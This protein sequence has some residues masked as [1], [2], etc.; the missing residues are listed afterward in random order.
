[1]TSRFLIAI[2]LVVSAGAANTGCIPS[3]ESGLSDSFVN[4]DVPIVIIDPDEIVVPPATFAS[5]E[6]EIPFG[7]FDADSD[8][9]ILWDECPYPDLEGAEPILRIGYSV[10]G[11][12][13]PIDPADLTL[14]GEPITVPTCSEVRNFDES[15]RIAAATTTSG[16][17]HL[18]TWNS[19]PY[20]PTSA[21]VTFRIAVDDGSFASEPGD[22]EFRVA[23][24]PAF[25]I[26]PL[27]IRPG[28]ELEVTLSGVLTSWD[29]TTVVDSSGEI[30]VTNFVALSSSSATATFEHSSD[31]AQEPRTVTLVTPG[32]GIGGADEVASGTIWTCPGVGQPV[33][34]YETAQIEGI[35]Q[36]IC[37]QGD[38]VVNGGLTIGDTDTFL[39]VANSSGNGSFV[40]NWT[41]P[42]DGAV[43]DY[44]AYLF[45]PLTGLNTCD[46]DLLGCDCATIAKPETCAISGMV[47]GQEY[48]LVITYYAGGAWDY[49]ATITAP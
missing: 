35:D 15:I 2:S 22:A 27:G 5:L 43:D 20:I 13:N 40:M 16:A 11:T 44:D 4:H 19:L 3:V 30:A 38:F 9:V 17:P 49:T 28:E 46:D 26:D 7:V 33:V 8:W 12:F 39:F 34:E 25:S 32:A 31:D 18:L 47:A 21:E 6:F 14:D 45:S 42:G 23:N 41:S 24:L 48:I 10:G 37:D 1:M 36:Y 29:G